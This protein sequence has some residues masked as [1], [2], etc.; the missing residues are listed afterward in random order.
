MSP[1]QNIK[2]REAKKEEGS[3]LEKEVN[4]KESKGFI[5]KAFK[6]GFLGAA[7]V[8]ATALGIATVGIT[9][10]L[11]AGAFAGGGMLGSLFNKN[12]S[13]YESITDGLKTYS[14]VNAV[15]YPLIGLAN[16]TYPV[17]GALG[18]SLAGP[19]GS[20]AAK[21]AYAL[22]AYNAAFLASFKAAE[23]L[24]DNYLNPMGITKAVTDNFGPFAKRIALGFSPAYIL[25][26]NGIS[27][28]ALA[29]MQ[30]PVFAL[31]AFPLGAYNAAN[32]LPEK[33][34]EQKAAE[35]PAKNYL[36]SQKGLNLAPQ[37]GMG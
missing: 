25:S 3:E 18:S 20:F 19:V 17:V 15:L 21:S 5:R 13:M 27:E 16:A 32:P 12:K 31:N 36:P 24:L 6:L 8:A 28:L 34:P 29:G 14:A 7:A 2:E 22:T 33:K 9:A 4:N 30:V 11:V 37:P 35:S 23:H 26:A 1:G 10:P